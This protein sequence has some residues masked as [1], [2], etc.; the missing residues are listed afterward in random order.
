DNGPTQVD[1]A[2]IPQNAFNLA[3]ERG[4]SNFDIRNRFV[5]SAIY[6]LPFGHGRSFGASSKL[7]NAI[8]GGLTVKA[9]ISAQ[10]GLP[11]NPVQS[12]DQSNTGTTARPNRIAS[13]A[14]PD[15]QRGYRRWFDTSAFTTPAQYTFGNAGRDILR[16]PGF[17]NFDLAL[18]KNAKIFERTSGELRIEAFNV[19]NT[20]QFGL[21]NAT[22]GQGTTAAI[23]TVVNPQRQIQAAIR[24]AF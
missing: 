7:V 16:G 5:L 6:D 22:L 21:P 11:F 14:L 3:A 12:V 20:P 13:G 17:H 8:A 15:A 1:N 19:L 2:P 24:I 23:S 4:D 9:I 18:S 10:G